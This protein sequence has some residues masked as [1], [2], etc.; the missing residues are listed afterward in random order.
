M[1]KKLMTLAGIILAAVFLAAGPQK[2]ARA[3]DAYVRR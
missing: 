3:A 2:A 1:K